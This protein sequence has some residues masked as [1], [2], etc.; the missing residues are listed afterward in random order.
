MLIL[1]YSFYHTDDITLNV[2]VEKNHLYPS[3][4]PLTGYIE[5]VNPIIKKRLNEYTVLDDNILN[6]LTIPELR[7]RLNTPSGNHDHC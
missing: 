2:A 7:I 1:P 5:T 4:P 3:A 6:E